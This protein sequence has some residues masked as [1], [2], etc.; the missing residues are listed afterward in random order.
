MRNSKRSKQPDVD[1]L[2]ALLCW[3]CA[4]CEPGGRW[5][6]LLENPVSHS[7]EHSQQETR[8]TLSTFQKP[9]SASLLSLASVLE[10]RVR[11]FRKATTL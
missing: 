9:P 7:K 2:Q 4:W 11:A 3:N 10:K 6:P 8:A 5:G 1:S